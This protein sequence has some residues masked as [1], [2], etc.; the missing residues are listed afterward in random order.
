MPKGSN[1]YSIGI[2]AVSS[3][4]PFHS[5][6]RYLGRYE[7]IDHSFLSVYVRYICT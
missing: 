6:V 2:R 5:P 4:F 1:Y 7:S 3:F